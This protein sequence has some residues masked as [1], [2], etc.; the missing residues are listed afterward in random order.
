MVNHDDGLLLSCVSSI[1]DRSSSNK[2][3]FQDGT[4]YDADCTYEYFYYMISNGHWRDKG[5]VQA[6]YEDILV[7]DD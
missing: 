7:C 4:L 3:T 1:C 5:D 2:W 6:I